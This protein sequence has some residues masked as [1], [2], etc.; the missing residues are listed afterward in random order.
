MRGCI[1]ALCAVATVTAFD[2]TRP[3]TAPPTDSSPPAASSDTPA[4]PSGPV[5]RS[6]RPAFEI[7]R[8]GWD[9]ESS[10][11]VAMSA[12]GDAV[13]LFQDAGAV[14]AL[15]YDSASDSFT[16]AWRLS[17]DGAA[18]AVSPALV[19]MDDHGGAIASWTAP[20]CSPRRVVGRQDGGPP[21]QSSAARAAV[22]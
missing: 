12:T 13:V 10:L 15:H 14:W 4:A 3:L 19:A 6:W 21:K 17:S 11:Q 22:T 8:G 1:R 20:E 7:G 2:C 18:P 9:A 16:P 5:I